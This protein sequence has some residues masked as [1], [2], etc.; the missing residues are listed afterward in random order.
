MKT[1]IVWTKIFK[2]EWFSSLSSDA[3]E[4][5][6]FLTFG[7]DIGFTGIFEI[8]DRTILFNLPFMK[9]DIKKLEKAKKQLS[10]KIIF[11]QGWVRVINCER[12]NTFRGKKLDVASK[13]ELTKIPENIKSVL[14]SINSDM[15]SIPYPYTID[16][17]NNNNNNN[18][19][20]LINNNINTCTST[21]TQ[22]KEINKEKEV[23]EKKYSKV[24]D[25]TQEDLED[26]AKEYSLK[27]EYV[28]DVFRRM[29]DWCLAKGKP[30]ANY[31][32]GLRTW[33][34][35]SLDKGG[36][37]GKQGFSVMPGSS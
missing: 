19:N 22:E 15:V 1:R 6:F 3:R 12:Y 7:E 30:Y 34:N 18:N 33:L 26:L 36:F 25:I 16:T 23:K 24:T 10:P 2:D 21:N 17:L 27:L 37:R 8:A 5:F 31:K 4:L 28:E 29:Q 14:L 20:I 32:S 11:F 9:G 35:N 13:K